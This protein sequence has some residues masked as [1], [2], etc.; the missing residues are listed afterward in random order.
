MENQF[1]P[2]RPGIGMLRVG[3]IR[4]A[5]DL[6]QEMGE[7]SANVIRSSGL[8]PD[9]FR[10]PENVV[11]FSAAVRFLNLCARVS[12]R[13]HFGL[14]AGAR[15]DLS[16]LGL[17][18]HL[19]QSAPDVG[20]ALSGLIEHM[21]VHDHVAQARLTIDGDSG[22]LAYLVDH[23]GAPGADQLTDGAIATIAK[24][25]GYLCG[26]KWAPSLVKL[27]RRPP[28]NVEP[29]V[30]FF[31]AHVAFGS[32]IAA[33]AFPVSWLNN[34]VPGAN[35]SLHKFLEQLVRQAEERLGSQAEE[36]RRIIRLQ[37]IGGKPGIDRAAAMLG[38][39]RRTLA[40]HLSSEGVTFRTLVQEVRFE[41]AADLMKK[42]DAS[43][44]R[45]AEL[46]G[47]SDQTAFSR[48]FSKRYGHPP[49]R[50]RNT[51]S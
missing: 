19:A 17:I 20:T 13:P 7:D 8:S 30:K 49:S 33:L 14:L 26:S 6:L 37:L 47:Y 29:Y 50:F 18:G 16:S 10:D 5:V 35:E 27:P 3:G 11:P 2:K 34:A 21:S 32:D 15:N 39:H 41:M 25:M 46:L 12:G 4:A 1:P 40:R 42:T 28:R 51:A 43:M 31:K 23:P 48:A 45:I 44:S 24:I 36:I 22:V 38:I 9:M